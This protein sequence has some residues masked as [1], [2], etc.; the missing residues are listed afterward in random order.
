MTKNFLRP[1]SENL[2][3]LIHFLTSSCLFA[4]ISGSKTNHL[5]DLEI[6]SFHSLNYSRQTTISQSSFFRWPYEEVYRKMISSFSFHARIIGFVN[7]YLHIFLFL[8]RVTGGELF[9]RI[10]AKG[11]YTEKDASDLIRQV[12]EAVNYMHEQGVV[13]RDLKVN[14]EHIFTLLSPAASVWHHSYSFFFTTLHFL[15]FSVDEVDFNS[16]SSSNIFCV[17]MNNKCSVLH[18]RLS[19]KIFNIYFRPSCWQQSFSLLEIFLIP[20]PE[21][22]T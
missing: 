19:M 13:H 7:V 10:V 11:S 1:L 12:L 15:Y 2:S 20:I 14:V 18:F 6:S 4:N 9:D 22:S 5:F 8:R 3:N 16:R 17:S 21:W